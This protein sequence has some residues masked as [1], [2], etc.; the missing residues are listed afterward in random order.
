MNNLDPN[1]IRTAVRAWLAEDVGRG[2]RTTAAVVPGSLMGR[3]RLEG[4]A[5][6]VVA[7]LGVAALCFEEGSAGA[8]KFIAERDDGEV[9]GPGDDLARVEG[10]LAPILTIERTALNVLQRLS[11]V[12]T[13]TARFV[14]E[15]DGTGAQVIDTRK[16]TPGLRAFEKYAVVVGGGKNHRGGLDDGILVKDNHITAAGGVEAA[17]R[18]ALE[19]A[20]Y[21]LFVEVEVADLVQLETAIAAGADAV[22]LDN[23]TPDEVA[24]AVEVAAGRV[25]LEASGGITLDNIR[26]FATAGV[27][28]ISIGALTHSAP[29]IDIALE[30]EG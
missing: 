21:G 22:L 4:R 3:A 1:L 15:C 16:T 28:T 23:M 27:D 29:S 10:P 20:P 26:A 9:F 17:T 19:G 14:K 24:A 8:V 13:L 2:D 30:V 6:G 18:R 5:E 25:R 11:G 12:A 7:G